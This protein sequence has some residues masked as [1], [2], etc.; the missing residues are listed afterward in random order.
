MTTTLITPNHIQPIIEAGL[1]SMAEVFWPYAVMPDVLTVYQR[2]A[3][4]QKFLTS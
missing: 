4:D 3:N 1:A 2:F